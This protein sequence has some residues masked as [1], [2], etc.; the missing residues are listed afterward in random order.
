MRD[1]WLAA[2]C[3]ARGLASFNFMIYPACLPVL[4]DAWSMSATAA[5][6][7]SAAFQLAFG[8]STLVSSWLADRVGAQRV[9]RVMAALTGVASVLF[10]LF[11][12]SYPTGLA[13]A[14]LVGLAQGGTY[15]TVIM[16]AADRY[17]PER[18]GAAMGWVL[19]A[20]SAG[21]AVSLLAAGAAL[22]AGGYPF[23][24]AVCAVASVAGAALFAAALRGT[25]N[26]IHRAAG[27]APFRTAVLGN[28]DAVRLTAAYTFHT[29]ETIGMWAWTPAFL[30][31]VL[32]ASGAGTVKAAE[33][34][35]YISAGLHFVGM[36]ASSMTG[37]MSDRFGRRA[38]LVAMAGASTACSFVFG[39]TVAWPFWIVA[40]LAVVYNFTAIGDSPVLSVA[41]SEAVPPA[42]LGAA[43]ALRSVLGFPMGAL[44]PLVFG[45]VLDAT[46]PP[47][48]TPSVWGWAFV[49]LG[50]GGAVA[51]AAAWSFG[52][53]TGRAGAR[54]AVRP[55]A[56][57]GEP[58]AP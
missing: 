45:A 42:H 6:S 29:Y 48:A 37:A 2:V 21:Y 41:L 15:T 20:S 25:P 47:G 34:G 4:V 11:A 36:I 7:V 44:A 51:T 57:A 14:V 27:Q 3:T 30:A 22:A 1:P 52:R 43:L 31:A 39:W 50:L 35:A 18:R 49:M 58:G 26:T 46:N 9:C 23:A 16:L 54:E 10:A 40:A 8:A 56:P 17:G 5:G 24:F 13:L 28:R 12:R 19:G 33:I 55:R 53:R 32:A 38:V